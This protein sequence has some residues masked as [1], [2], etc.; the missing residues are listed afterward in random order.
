MKII[1]S[2]LLVLSFVG[3][4]GM[5]KQANIAKAMENHQF[6]LPASAVYDAASDKFMRVATPLTKV[7]DFEGV[8]DWNVTEPDPKTP[9]VKSRSRF[10]VLVEGKGKSTLKVFREDEYYLLAKW[11]GDIQS[12]RAGIYE[13][14]ILEILDPAKAQEIDA[15]AAQ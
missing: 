2:A 3:C 15:A 11:S 5:K 6:D 13:Y 4:A 10:R 8:T 7:K 12:V 1:L 9:G 14:N